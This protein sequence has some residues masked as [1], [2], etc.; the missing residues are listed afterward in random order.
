MAKGE[1]R[2]YNSRQAKEVWSGLQALLDRGVLDKD[3]QE[4]AKKIQRN[5]S[6]RAMDSP[7]LTALSFSDEEDSLLSQV[8]A[9][10]WR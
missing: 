10:L 6:S 3:D 1:W 8:E 5:L 9:A 4:T 2:T 7:D